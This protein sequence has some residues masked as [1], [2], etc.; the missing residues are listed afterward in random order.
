MRWCTGGKSWKAGPFLRDGESV[1]FAPHM[2]THS[3]G[4]HLE[5]TSQEPQGDCLHALAAAQVAQV[6]DGICMHIIQHVWRPAEA[7][8]RH[9]A[10]VNS[11]GGSTQTDFTP[12]QPAES[13]CTKENI[14]AGGV[15][16]VLLQ[17]V[18]SLHLHYQ[19]ETAIVIAIVIA[20]VL[21]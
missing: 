11:V 9:F 13:I 4:V 16:R 14:D 15:F 21:D 8:C 17:L 10:S 5:L 3:R 1:N 6:P 2:Y 20:F 19:S 7:K 18:N 12:P